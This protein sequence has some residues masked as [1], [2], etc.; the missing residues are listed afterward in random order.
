MG[1]TEYAAVAFSHTFAGP[2][3]VQE[4]SALLNN[5]DTI[6]MIDK[7]KFYCTISD[8]EDPMPTLKGPGFGLRSHSL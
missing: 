7:K 2:V 6:R 8:R 1:T 4:A 3:I 5:A